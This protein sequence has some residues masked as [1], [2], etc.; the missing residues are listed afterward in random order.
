MEKIDSSLL[1]VIRD[2]YHFVSN[3]SCVLY[4]FIFVL[5]RLEEM[6]VHFYSGERWRI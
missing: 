4:I 1:V 2:L 3:L 6:S 5:D